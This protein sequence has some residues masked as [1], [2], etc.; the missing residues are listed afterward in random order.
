ME[1]C[2]G[3]ELF[4]F[5]I[6]R[7]RVEEP[8]AKRLFKQ[9]V[10]AVGYIHSQNVVH[11]DLKPENMLLTETCSV[12]LID[13][14][15]CNSNADKPLHN[16]CGSSCYIAP[17]AL[18]K[19][20]YMGIPAD[21]WA[22]GVIL[23][24]LVD[25]TLP[26]NYQDPK[27]MYQQITTGSFPIPNGI[28]TQCIDLLKGI[29]NPDVGKRLTIE[30]ILMH[31]WLFA[32]GNV[33]PLPKTISPQLT[34]PRLNISV[35][36]FSASNIRSD[37]N[38]NLPNPSPSLG[39]ICENEQSTSPLNIMNINTMNNPNPPHVRNEMLSRRGKNQE[40]CTIRKNP[41]HPRSISLDAATMTEKSEND[42]QASTHHGSIMS[43]TISSRD[44]TI[45]AKYF[46]DTLQQ[47]G[48]KYIKINPLLFQ[49]T[50]SNLQLTAEVC[51]LY[52]F[53]NVY[54]ISF[55]RLQ[56]DSWGYTQFVSKF[57]NVFKI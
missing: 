29:L 44:P 2:G 16:R 15:L 12:K 9:I 22:L 35:G 10:L 57:L 23:Y 13:F 43:Q 52:G 4:D 53:R 11:R 46:E 32:V 31:P 39:T 26:W 7:K 6:S 50:G 55:K 24:S 34:E 21:I 25:G 51:R 30:E 8:L 48:I 45:I 18:T 19:Q 38:F 5:I 14:G 56:G 27:E 37:F 41:I 28:S 33:F 42:N 49:L 3:G 54:I 47:Y 36:G 20:E 40:V 1:Y 17:E